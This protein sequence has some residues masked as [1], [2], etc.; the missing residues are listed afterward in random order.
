M[1]RFVDL[2]DPAD[3]TVPG[4][5]AGAAASGIR[6]QGR[7]DLTLLLSEVPAVAAGVFTSNRVKA[8][9]VVLSSEH[10]QR[11]ACRAIVANSGIANA[12]TGEEGLQ[13]ARTVARASAEAIGCQAEE[14]LLASTGVIGAQLPLTPILQALPG[15]VADCRPDGWHD[16]AAAIMTTDTAEKL[17][18][19]RGNLGGTSFNL[20]GIAKGAG[21]IAPQ[22]ATMLAFVATDAAVAPEALQ[23]MLS[24]ETRRSFNRITIDGDM[25][26]NDTVLVL[27]N[28]LASNRTIH[29][30]DSDDGRIFQE[31]LGHTL[32]ILARKI[33]RDAEGGTKCVE[34]KL[35]SAAT[36]EQALRGARTVAESLLVKTALF[37]QDPNW[38]RIM[39]AL[40]RAAI[41]FVPERVTLHFDAVKVVENGVLVSEE[42]E[43]AAA[44]VMQRAEYLITIDLQQGEARESVFTCD[45]SLDYVRINADYRS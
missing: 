45:L 3:H 28:G 14:V 19:L 18:C 27:A 21:M 43:K 13:R 22:M 35:T 20:L 6:Y 2:L 25:S 10:L 4:F 24:A 1:D 37:G 17:H 30:A 38:G 29:R 40:G 9:P 15:L 7:P 36:R 12:C 44:E 41:D 39:A 11:G 33:L 8:A 32:A 42:Q 16:A 26:T 23:T 31:A 5:V 34:I